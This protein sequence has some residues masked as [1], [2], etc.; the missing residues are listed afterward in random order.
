MKTFI[1]IA[2]AESG[3]D[4]EDDDTVTIHVAGGL[5]EVQSSLTVGARYYIGDDGII[6]DKIPD[7]ESFLYRA[8]VATA[9]TKLLVDGSTLGNF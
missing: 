9:T 7:K 2:D 1:G 6:R 4:W 3:G 8:G 5:N